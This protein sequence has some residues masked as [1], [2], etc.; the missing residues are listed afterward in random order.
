MAKNYPPGRWEVYSGQGVWGTDFDENTVLPNTIGGF[1]IEFKNTTPA[2][3]PTLWTE[4]HITVEE[5]HPYLA[6]AKARADSVAGGNTMTLRV[7]WYTQAQVYISATDIYS[8]ILPAVDTWYELSGVIDAVA[9][10]RFAKILIRKN[11]TAFTG[12]F[13]YAGMKRLPRCFHAYLNASANHATG[14]TVLFDTET[15]DYGSTF[16]AANN[17]WVCPSTGVWSLKTGARI[18]LLDTDEHFSL[19]FEIDTGGGFGTLQQGP[20]LH[21]YADDLNI[22]NG[23]ACERYFTRGDEVIVTVAH[24]HAGAL[25][26]QGIVAGYPSTWI[27]GV[28]IR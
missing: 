7:H 25:Q 21:A 11:N 9:N 19:N 8:A 4:K 17:K 26:L 15:Y 24:G 20:T 5:G 6:K 28:E 14:A 10:A 2:S 3:D 16:D 1:C 13:D 23:N 18:L 27:S 22:V 12:Y